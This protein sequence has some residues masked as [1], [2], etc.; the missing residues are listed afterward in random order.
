ML[1]NNHTVPDGNCAARGATTCWRMTAW[2][3]HPVIRLYVGT[4]MAACPGASGTSQAQEFRGT[5][6]K[7]GP[8]GSPVFASDIGQQPGH[9]AVFAERL[10]AQ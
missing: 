9:Y 6:T 4:T 5:T 2:E 10:H 8:S 7:L 3:V 1:D